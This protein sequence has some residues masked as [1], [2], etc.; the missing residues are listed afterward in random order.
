MQQTQE[1]KDYYFRGIRT[2]DS[3]NERPQNY[4]LD[5]PATGAGQISIR[6]PTLLVVCGTVICLY[7]WFHNGKFKYVYYKLMAVRYSEV[8]QKYQHKASELNSACVN[9]YVRA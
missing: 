3:S 7:V 2:H 5:R 9:A 4:A 1:E 8:G 6:R